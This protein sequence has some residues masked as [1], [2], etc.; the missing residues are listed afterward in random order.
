MH[1]SGGGGYIEKECR[2]ERLETKRDETKALAVEKTNQ[3]GSYGDKL[4]QL[5]LYRVEPIGCVVWPK[6]GAGV[7]PGQELYDGVGG[8]RARCTT[9]ASYTLVSF[10][11]I[12]AS[13]GLIPTQAL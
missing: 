12:R 2:S 4:G 6:E 5:R 1:K 3:H 8:D 10:S 7:I 13:L 9:T 11:L